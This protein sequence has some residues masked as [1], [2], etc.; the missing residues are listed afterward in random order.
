MGVVKA[1]DQQI[2]DRLSQL[3]T[4]QKEVVLSVVKSFAQEEEDWWS[5]VE[6]AAQKSI[7]KGMKEANEGKITAHKDVMKKYKKWLPK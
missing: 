4:K 1:L 3:N 5:D 2:T 7:A 6:N